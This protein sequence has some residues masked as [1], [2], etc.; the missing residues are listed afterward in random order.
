MY[1]KILIYSFSAT[2]LIYK[3]L[4]NKVYNLFYYFR[5]DYKKKL[6]ND[7]LEKYDDDNLTN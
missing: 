6:Q 5:I 3:S 4:R 7:Y 1:F 2:K